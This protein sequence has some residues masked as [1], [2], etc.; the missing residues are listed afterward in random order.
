M[1]RLKSVLAA[2][3]LTFSLTV[4]SAGQAPPVCNP[5]DTHSPPCPATLPQEDT[6]LMPVETHT[7]PEVQTVEIVTLV[8]LAL[9]ALLLA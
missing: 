2:V 7:L 9:H 8:E 4:S 3:V 6:P 5:G 1:N